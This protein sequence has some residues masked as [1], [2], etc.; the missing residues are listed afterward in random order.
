M[1]NVVYSEDEFNYWVDDSGEHLLHKPNVVAESRGS[2]LAAYAI[3]E[4]KDEGIYMEV[5]S[6]SQ[7][8]QVRGVSKAKKGPWFDWYDEM[9]RKTVIRRLSKRLPM[10]TDLELVIQRDD[11]LYDLSKAGGRDVAAPGGVAGAKAVLGLPKFSDADPDDAGQDDAGA[12]ADADDTVDE[13]TGEVVNAEAKFTE[14]SAIKLLESKR[15]VKTLTEAYDEIALD[16]KGR[17]EIPPDAVGVKFQE[18]RE[19]LAEREKV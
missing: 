6:R 17:G 5:M 10:S 9:A 19:S 3:A 4:T 15:T 8:E 18:M 16:Y 13:T 12:G 14:E 11:S 2:F 7:I 1:S